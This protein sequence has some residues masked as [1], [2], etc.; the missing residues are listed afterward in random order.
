MHQKTCLA[1]VAHFNGPDKSFKVPK[2]ALFPAPTPYVTS[3]SIQGY[4]ARAILRTLSPWPIEI[5]TI[6]SMPPLV[7][8][9]ECEKRDCNRICRSGIDVRGGE[10]RGYSLVRSAKPGKRKCKNTDNKYQQGK[11]KEIVFYLWAKCSPMLLHDLCSAR[12]QHRNSVDING[13]HR[14]NLKEVF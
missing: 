2:I 12:Q 6:F 1:Q 10:T 8:S 5:F 11:N 13:K 14:K 9:S 7:A 4:M 3:T